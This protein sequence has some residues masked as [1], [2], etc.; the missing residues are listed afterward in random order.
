[1]KQI[2]RILYRAGLNR[3]QALAELAG[4]AQADTAEFQCMLAFARSSQRGMAPGGK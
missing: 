4:D 2:H 3:T 1:M